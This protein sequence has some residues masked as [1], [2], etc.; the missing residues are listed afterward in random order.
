METKY[1]VKHYDEKERIVESH[2]SELRRFFEK[3]KLSELKIELD[4]FT[5][6]VLSEESLKKDYRN[7]LKSLNFL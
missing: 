2:Q 1:H 5:I 6:E 7:S 4:Q 3:N